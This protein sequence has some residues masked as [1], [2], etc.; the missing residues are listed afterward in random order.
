MEFWEIA[1]IV[2]AVLVVVGIVLFLL[3]KATNPKYVLSENELE[4][5][6]ERERKT[7]FSPNKDARIA[8]V[9]AK[10]EEWKGE[11]QKKI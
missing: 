5:L 6:T 3:I 8:L 10:R 11:K 2:A 1:L 4:K 7:Y 9:K